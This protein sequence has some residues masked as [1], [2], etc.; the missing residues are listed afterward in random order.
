MYLIKIGI[1]YEIP[2]PRDQNQEEDLQG[3]NADALYELARK[4]QKSE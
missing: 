4:N 1:F 2:T 3:A